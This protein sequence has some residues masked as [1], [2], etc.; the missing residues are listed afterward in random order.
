VNRT[1]DTPAAR[2]TPYKAVLKASGVKV[3][4]AA[5]FFPA[6]NRTPKEALNICH[7]CPHE[8]DCLEWALDTRQNFA[9]L[10]GKTAEQRRAILKNREAK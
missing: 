8:A 10:G 9:V 5:V 6:D 2:S 4:N 7:T 1:H 3:Q